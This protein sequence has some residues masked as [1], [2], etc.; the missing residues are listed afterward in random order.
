MCVREVYAG[1]R[2]LACPC[3][4]SLE[5]ARVRAGTVEQLPQKDACSEA[6]AVEPTEGSDPKPTLTFHPHANSSRTPHH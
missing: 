1:V 6:C 3:V 5:C 4:G 2:A